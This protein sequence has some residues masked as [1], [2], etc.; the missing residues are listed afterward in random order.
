MF[1]QTV[2]PMT[3]AFVAFSGFTL[4][5]VTFSDDINQLPQVVGK[6][7]EEA[8]TYGADVF[9]RAS[10]RLSEAYKK[11]TESINQ[12]VAP[13]TGAPAPTSAPVPPPASATT[14]EPAKNIG[15]KKKGSKRNQKEKKNKTM[16]K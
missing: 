7:M 9:A 15:G 11:T 1:D 13:I 12:T 4:V 14:G 8:S 6:K 16:K 3:Y 10:T 2:P 5:Y